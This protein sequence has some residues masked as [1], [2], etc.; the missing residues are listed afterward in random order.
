VEFVDTHC[1]LDF[2][3]FDSDRPEVIHRALAAGIKRI[4]IPGTTLPASL[5]AVKVAESHPNLF[6]AVGIHP[7]EALTWDNASPAILSELA[8]NL[9]V[10]AIGEI[11]LDYYWDTAPH[12]YQQKVLKEQLALAAELKLPVILHMREKADAE[13]GV[14]AEDLIKILKEW[15]TRLREEKNPL[16]DTPGVLHSFSGS[17]ETANQ[18]INLNFFIG[19]TGP[20]TYKNAERRRQIIAGLPLEKMLIETDAPFLAPEPHR[21]HRNEPAYVRFIADKIG[22]LHQRNLEEVAAITSQNAMR[23]FSWGE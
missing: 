13:H 3:K 21:G 22:E 18:A 2:N 4:L 6:A 23:L 17:V 5:S 16:V 10:V 11:G 1:H 7:T 15:V 14:C 20:I 8:T 12:P 19:I 9:K